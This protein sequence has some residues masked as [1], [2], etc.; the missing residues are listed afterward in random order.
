MGRL[1]AEELLTQ[2]TARKVEGDIEGAIRLLRNAYEEVIKA[3]A[4]LPIEDFLRLP[5]C[6]H[7]AGRSREAWDEFNSL[8]FDGYPNQTKDAT[9]IA[10]DRAKI[11][12]RMRLFLEADGQKDI[13]TVFGIFSLVCKGIKLHFE[14]RQRELRTW[15][16]KSACHEFVRGLKAYNGNLG[17]LQGIQYA[18]VGELGEY[19]SIDFDLLAQRIDVTLRS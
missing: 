4:L 5:I 6:L 16:S 1:R 3:N 7:Q 19:P 10:Q 18:V 8:L 15:F 14:G 11:F 9:L 13:A 2:A 12:D 17:K